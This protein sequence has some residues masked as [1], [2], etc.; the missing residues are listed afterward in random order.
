MM[1]PRRN[2][3]K[4]LTMT[5][6]LISVM[7]LTGVAFGDD[8]KVYHQKIVPISPEKTN[9]QYCFIRVVITQEGDNIV[10]KEILECADGRNKFDGP[11]YWELF[12]QFYYRDVS[13]P[14]YCRYYSRP[15]HVFKS[16]GKTC[17]STNGEWE[18][19]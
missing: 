5:L 14:E 12:A 11:S 15:K 18:V 9:G 10:K 7:L 19:Q 6:I 13:T 1:D 8:N 16:H 4:Y 3:M 17:L 2:M